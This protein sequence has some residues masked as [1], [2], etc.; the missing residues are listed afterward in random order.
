MDI[1][2]DSVLDHP[3]EKQ[4]EYASLL[5]Y[6]SVDEWREDTIKS[7]KK[8]DELIEQA[9]NY[10]RTRAEVAEL[11]HTL[12]T[13]PEAIGY[14]QRITGNYDLTAEEQIRHL[15]SLKTID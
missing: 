11:V 14:Y 12:R 10:K 4:K 9:S 2:T 15:E 5:G 1:K 8:S 6:D 7:F 13:Y 3:I